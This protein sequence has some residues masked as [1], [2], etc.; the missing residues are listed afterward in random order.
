[1]FDFNQIRSLLTDF[2]VEVPS[3]KF[4][5]NLSVGTALIHMDRQTDGHESK[6]LFFAIYPYTPKTQTGHICFV[7]STQERIFINN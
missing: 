3:I 4:H 6:S 5:D 2:F 1:M 7:P